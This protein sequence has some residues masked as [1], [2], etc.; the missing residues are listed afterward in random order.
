MGTTASGS[1]GDDLALVNEEM[2]LLKDDRVIT[3]LRRIAS[4]AESPSN[5]YVLTDEDIRHSGATDIPT[6]LRRIPGLDVMQTTG[7]DFNV[8]VRGDNQVL[9]NKLLVLIDG[10]SVY[11]DVQGTM[12][13]RSFPITLPEIKRIEVVKGPIEALYG[14]NAFDGVIHII[15]KS[16]EEMRGTTVQVGAGELGTVI[17]SAVH[18]GTT[19]KFGYRLSAGEDQ[20]QQW[21]NRDG[22]AVRTYRFNVHT[23]YDL[24]SSARLLVSGGMADSNRFDGPL[25]GQGAN[26]LQTGVSLP[27]SQI[28]YE[29]GTFTVRAFW[30]GF[31]TDS[32]AVSHPSLDGLTQV[33]T[34]DGSNLLAFTGNTYNLEAQ[35]SVRLWDAHEMTYG[36]N[37]RYNSLSC[38][39]TAAFGRENRLGLF[40][41]DEW[42]LA[43]AFI[44]VAGLR[45]DLHTE[46]HQTWSPRLA[47]IYTLAPG[48]TLRANVSV[49]Y[50][51]P[52]L[53]ET[54]EDL[55]R[56]FA[57]STGLPTVTLMGTSGLNPEQIVSYEVGYQGRWRR[58]TLQTSLFF[59]HISDLIATTPLSPT[60]QQNSNGGE[61]DIYGVEAG[62]DLL[63]ASWLS[64][65]ANV[66]YQEIG[67]TNSPPF[68]RG[69]PRLKFNAGMRGDWENGWSGELAWHYVGAATYPIGSTFPLLVPF[70]GPVID[71]RVGSYSLLN[72][73]AGYRFW[74]QR[75]A[76][77][78]RREAEAAI[79]V[80]NAL[81]DK[82]QEHPLGDTIG[83]RV[84]GWVTVRF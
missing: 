8:S 55:R 49:A 64:A 34:R 17:S 43:P 73:R 47:L 60:L 13:W 33:L 72:L 52:T 11:V 48:Q 71:P 10:R 67:Q 80:F 32:L 78:Y 25:A 12:F 15:T 21:R 57:G 39:C 68:Q 40:V 35:H 18:A 75:A 29:Q 30:S 56:I 54:Q 50:R 20:N 65:F 70:G 5:V 24:S 84:M 62:A 14:F 44:A 77:G 83:S 46:I 42:R 26:I 63:A 4:I 74:Q 66:T 16:P 22:L 58:L 76:A 61:A 36:I 59:N 31:F 81:N 38:S 7:A 28:A 19:G 69:A 23:T 37:Y 45:Y 9:A 1:A 2:A 53:F 3:P 79:S 82:H 41:Q 6:L 27:Y 51:P